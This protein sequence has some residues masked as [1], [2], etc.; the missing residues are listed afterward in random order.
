MGGGAGND[1]VEAGDVGEE[2]FGRLR[3]VA[4]QCK[5]L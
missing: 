1:D 5:Y 2:C 4:I 3:V